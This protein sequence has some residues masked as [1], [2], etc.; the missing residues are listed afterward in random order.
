MVAQVKLIVTPQQS[1]AL[2]RT[3]QTANAACDYIS[4]HA[5]ETKT[6]QQFSLHKETYHTVREKFPIAAQM[7][8]RCNA[9][10]ADAY[11]LDKATKR[12]FRP[13]GSIAY[14]DRILSWKIEKST[15][16]VWTVDG[17]ITMPFVCG[18]YQREMLKTQQGETDLALVDGQFYLL[19]VCN[20]EEPP[21]R[22]TNGFLGIDLG[23]VT[24]VSDNEGRQYSGEQVNSLRRR[25]RKHRSGLQHQAMKRHSRS[26]YRRLKAKNRKQSRFVKWLNHNISKQIIQNALSSGKALALEALTGIRERANGFCTEMRWQMGNW[27]FYQLASFVVYK[28]KKSGIPVVFVDPRNTSRTCSSCGYC[29]KANRKSQSHFVCLQCGREF[30]ADMNAALNI[31]TRATVTSPMVAPV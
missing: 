25:V 31:A 17:R 15:V 19:A 1:D 12:I 27:S 4:N 8:V 16:S 24:I 11:K 10:V 3:M 20:V 30:N 5:W 2:L 7:V 22:E 26:A 28:A 13:F 14:D 23:I 6:F 18:D 21:F 29:D 9:K